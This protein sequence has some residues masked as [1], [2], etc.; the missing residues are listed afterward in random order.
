VLVITLLARVVVFQPR[1]STSSAATDDSPLCA[2]GI[3]V[4]RL[5]AMLC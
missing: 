3:V 4:A 2:A 1:G 5:K